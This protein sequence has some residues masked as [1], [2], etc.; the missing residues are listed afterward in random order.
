MQFRASGEAFNYYKQGKWTELE[1][2]FKTNKINDGW[3]PAN[4]GYN[5]LDNVPIKKGMKFDRY[6]VNSF[7][8]D[9]KGNPILGGSYTSPVNV[10]S[11]SFGQRSLENTESSYG[12]FYEIEVINDLPFTTMDADVIPWHDKIGGG[13]QNY[14]KIPIDPNTGYPMTWNKLAE[15]GYIKITIKKSPSGQY[16]SEIGKVIGN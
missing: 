16:S 9:A 3:P 10:K 1:E 14:W 8:T 6:Q 4:G 15:E 2:L 11:F 7:G 13:K 12:L 5:I